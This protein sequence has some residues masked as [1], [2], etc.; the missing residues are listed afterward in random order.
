MQSNSCIESF[1]EIHG[2]ML[3]ISERLRL[4]EYGKEGVG[5][6]EENQKL[7][8]LRTGQETYEA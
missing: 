5:V 8:L 7:S 1:R 6:S 4:M 3:F 2:D